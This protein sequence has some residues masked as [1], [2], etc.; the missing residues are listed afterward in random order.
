MA[1]LG[2]R[3]CFTGVR[4]DRMVIAEM[5]VNVSPCL[6]C[7]CGN[8]EAVKLMVPSVRLARPLLVIMT[9]NGAVRYVC[10]LPTAPRTVS[11]THTRL[12][13]V[14]SCANHVQHIGRLSRAACVPRG[15]KERLNYISDKVK[16]VFVLALFHWLEPFT[17]AE[18]EETEVPRE[19]PRRRLLW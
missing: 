5:S 14:I 13:H 10:Y 7:N 17:T 11:N 12:A 18:W 4:K 15:T 9:L 1:S 2:E 16:I 19:N 6:D 8:D 3:P